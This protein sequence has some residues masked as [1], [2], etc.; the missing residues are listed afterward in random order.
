MTTNPRVGLGYDIHRLVEGRPLILGGVKIDHP[1]GPFAHSDGDVV[2]HAIIDALLGA[3][4][5]GDIGELF[6]DTDPAHKDA[7]SAILLKQVVSRV[8]DAGFKP[9]NVDVNIH[10]EKPKLSPHKPAIRDS[11]AK[12]LDLDPGCV[13]IKAKTNETLGP[14]GNEQAIACTTVVMLIAA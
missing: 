4:A 12:L 14:I 11:V 9:T 3:A 8:R 7:D 10:A 2:L 5:L 13:N 1:K 6:P